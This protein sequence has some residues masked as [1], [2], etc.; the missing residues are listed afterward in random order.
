MF[1]GED[2]GTFPV[3][4]VGPKENSF[5]PQTDFRMAHSSTDT[6]MGSHHYYG[7]YYF[8]PACFNII[9]VYV[10]V[11]MCSGIVDVT[12]LFVVS[13]VLAGPSVCGCSCTVPAP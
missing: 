13:S 8:A 7:K 6:C 12:E 4:L 9:R 5:S 2:D 10:Y 3:S 1:G 11:Y